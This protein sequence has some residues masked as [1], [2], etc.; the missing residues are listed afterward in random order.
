MQSSRKTIKRKIKLINVIK[1]ST[2]IMVLTKQTQVCLTY[3][4]WWC[5]NEQKYHAKSPKTMTKTRRV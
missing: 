4:V 1:G 2:K 3:Y 5:R